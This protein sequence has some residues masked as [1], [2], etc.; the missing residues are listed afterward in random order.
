MVKKCRIPLLLLG[1]CLLAAGAA[2]AAA[3][4]P[5]DEAFSLDEAYNGLS[6]SLTAHYVSP[7][8]WPEPVRA[9]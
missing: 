3:I 2:A 9:H 7:T 4:S 6:G 1:C 5:G 8:Y